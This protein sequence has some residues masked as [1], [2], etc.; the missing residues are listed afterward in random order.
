MGQ[1]YLITDNEIFCIEND[2]ESYDLEDMNANHLTMYACDG[3]ITRHACEG[4]CGI[5]RS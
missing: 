2:C 5:L 1:S 3:C 4:L